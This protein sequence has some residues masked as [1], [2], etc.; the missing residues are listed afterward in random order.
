MRP[1]LLS[2]SA[3]ALVALLV[4][5]AFG[6]FGRVPAPPETYGLDKAHSEVLFRVR[7][8][9]ISTV[10]GRFRDFD[11]AISVDPARLSTLTARATI[12]A[13]SV[14]TEN[15]RRDNHLRSA[16]FFDVA[17]HPT[18]TFQST[19]VRNV[20]A[21]RFLLDG[22]LTMHGVTRPVT[23]NVEYLGLVRDARGNEK[24]GFA[25]TGRIN[26]E[27]YGM[28]WNQA[29]EAGGVLVSKEVDLQFN[30]QATRRLAPAGTN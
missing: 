13:A 18:L 12:Q 27:D 7:H 11:A 2:A 29:I 28:T 19:R 16:D 10:T 22:T 20:R 9:G 23:L 17:A 30:L 3:L 25:A 1:R 14:D 26:R 15:E 24:L 6:P 8:L 21:R 5:P 4:L